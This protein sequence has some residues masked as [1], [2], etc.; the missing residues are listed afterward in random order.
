MNP[1][2][3]IIPDDSEQALEW[4]VVVPGQIWQAACDPYLCT[5]VRSP[6]ATASF[7]ATIV[8]SGD[9]AITVLEDAVSLEAAQAWRQWRLGAGDERLGE[10]R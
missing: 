1:P 2:L 8:R 3:A 5:V 6:D 10:T 4:R 7:Y 9:L